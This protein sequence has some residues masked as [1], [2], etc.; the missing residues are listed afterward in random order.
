MSVH[1][2]KGKKNIQKPTCITR[3]TGA[4]VRIDFVHAGGTVTTRIGSALVLVYLAI[5]SGSTDRA[6]ANVA[7]DPVVADSLVQARV[8]RALVD[9]GLAPTSGETR[10][11]LAPKPVDPVDT[12]P[13][14]AWVSLAVVDVHFAVVV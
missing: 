13:V 1:I 10:V 4:F 2:R 8:R 5:F 11:T 12:L 9:L 6:A 3:A 14:H 7:V